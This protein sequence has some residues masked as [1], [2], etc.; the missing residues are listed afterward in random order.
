MTEMFGL[1]RPLPAIITSSAR[2][3]SGR[4]DVRPGP[5][6]GGMG[7]EKSFPSADAASD[8]CSQSAFTCA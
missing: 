8:R 4:P 3:K 1:K 5:S 7:S 2:K 6:Y